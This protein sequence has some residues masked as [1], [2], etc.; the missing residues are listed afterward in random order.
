MTRLA[1]AALACAFTA[2]AGTALRAQSARPS[3]PAFLPSSIGRSAACRPRGARRPRSRLGPHP[4]RRLHSR[5]PGEGRPQAPHSPPIGARC[6]RRT[7]LDLIG[8]PPTPEEQRAFLADDSPD[9]FA[10][11]V[12]D[13]LARPQYGERWGRHWLD[14]ARYAETNGYERDG[15]KP[16][17]WRYRDYVIDSFNQ[18]QAL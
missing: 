1:L 13:L 14:V 6:L 7:Y 9:A 8:L 12:D 5:P 2:A 11:V 18:R 17:A 4:H 3:G 15:A 16:N 10:K